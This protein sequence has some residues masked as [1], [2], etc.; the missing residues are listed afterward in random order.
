MSSKLAKQSLD[1]LLKA[2][3]TPVS[4]SSAS[5]TVNPKSKKIAKQKDG[6]LRL[7]KT[8]TGLK[9]IKHEIR[10][11]RHQRL[12]NQREKTEN[13]INPLGTPRL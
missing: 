13:N 5:S 9:M 6:R 1:A 4:A 11:G 8:K 7:P 3:A 12:K 10:Y 2:T